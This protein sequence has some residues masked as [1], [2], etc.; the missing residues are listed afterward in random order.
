MSQNASQYHCRLLAFLCVPRTFLSSDSQAKACAEQSTICC[1]ESCKQHL[2]YPTLTFYSHL[3]EV[4]AIYC[5]WHAFLHCAP[6]DSNRDSSLQP[7]HTV[8]LQLVSTRPFL[9]LVQVK[10]KSR[11]AQTLQRALSQGRST[12]S[13]SQSQSAL[14]AVP[15]AIHEE[16]AAARLSSTHIATSQT[17]STGSGAGERQTPQQV[18]S[19]VAALDGGAISKQEAGHDRQPA[20]RPV[21]GLQARDRQVSWSPGRGKPLEADEVPG[22]DLGCKVVQP[23]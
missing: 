18:S 9:V 8:P 10:S 3:F 2:L 22:D 7:V 15:A 6:A 20:A 5:L 12:L 11:V 1:A 4:S 23:P 19:Y 16:P 13:R 21:V 17:S 14:E